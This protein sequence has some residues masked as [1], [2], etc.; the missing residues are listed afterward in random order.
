MNAND[1]NVFQSSK[2]EKY[3]A[4]NK[5]LEDVCMADASCAYNCQ[6]WCPEGYAIFMPKPS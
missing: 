2:H 1:T 5:A 6:G 3:A 4:R